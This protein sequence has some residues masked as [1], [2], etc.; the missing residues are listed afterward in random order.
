LE[1]L[2]SIHR[3]KESLFKELKDMG[4]GLKEL[5][6]LFYTIKK[7]AIENKIPENQAVQKFLEDIEKNYDNKL[8]Y[9]S[10]ALLT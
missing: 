4:F 2:I 6:L 8:G 9:D 10:T 7:V 3:N 5:K 1:E